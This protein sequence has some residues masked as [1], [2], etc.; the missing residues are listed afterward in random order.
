[1]FARA[2]TADGLKVCPCPCLA[3]KATL[4]PEGRAAMVIGEEGKPQGLRAHQARSQGIE[5]RNLLSPDL[6]VFYA[7]IKHVRSRFGTG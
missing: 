1:M 5:L 6:R 7:Y 2:G 3:R 4:V